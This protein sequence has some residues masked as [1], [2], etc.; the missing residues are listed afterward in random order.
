MHDPPMRVTIQ[1]DG[2][3][4]ILWRKAILHV[5]LR[6]HLT[7]LSEKTSIQ[8]LIKLVSSMPFRLHVSECNPVLRL[9]SH[10]FEEH[11]HLWLRLQRLLIDISSVWRD[12]YTLAYKTHDKCVMIVINKNQVTLW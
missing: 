10:I 2:S 1:L 6:S 4:G 12:K 8:K 11:P 3:A 7:H 9:R 5:R